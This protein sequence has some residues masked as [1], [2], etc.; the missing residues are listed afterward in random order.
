MW[1]ALLFASALAAQSPGP[2]SSLHG[3][4][5]TACTQAEGEMAAGRFKQ[6]AAL[7]QTCERG[8]RTGLNLERGEQW[9]LQAHINRRMAAAR[10]ADGDTDGARNAVYIAERYEQL[11]RQIPD[12]ARDTQIRAMFD[13]GRY[14]EA[15]AIALT[16]LAE[17]EAGESTFSTHSRLHG[18]AR[19]LLPQGRAQEAIPL[20]E[21]AVDAARTSGERGEPFVYLND[22]AEAY[23][24]TGRF[25]HSAAILRGLYEGSDGSARETYGN[26]LARALDG[27][28]LHDEAEILLRSAVTDARASDGRMGSNPHRLARVLFN[29]ARNLQAQGRHDEAAS[30]FAESAAL[31]VQ[32]RP[33]GHTDI[34]AAHTWLTGH[35]LTRTGDAQA[36]LNGARILSANLDRYLAS[37]G[38]GEERQRAIQNAGEPQ[39]LFTLHVEAAWAAA[40]PGD[41]P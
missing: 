10:E 8:A 21:R 33:A 41:R 40:N 5:A 11:A 19:T 9:A 22:L 28:G 15:E 37:G 31:T 16:L 38:E 14:A 26:N 18:L 13:E 27:A 4:A 17:A 32:R 2:Y 35:T 20:L 24:D 3:D 36:A 23:F 12:H 1:T 39:A 7:F 30:L 25:T 34:I 6:A 29:L